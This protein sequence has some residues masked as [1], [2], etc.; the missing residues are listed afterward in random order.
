MADTTLRPYRRSAALRDVSVCSADPYEARVIGTRIYHPHHVSILGN[1][2]DFS[3]TIDAASIG[4]VTVGWLTYGTEVRIETQEFVDSYQINL[5]TEGVMDARC[6][7]EQIVATR[8]LAMVYRPDRPT[9]FSGWRTP[10]PMLAVKVTRHALERELEQLLD[11][12]VAGPIDF[13]LGLDVSSGRGAEW[14]NLLRMIASSLADED[15]LV[16]QPVIAAPLVHSVLTGLLLTARHEYREEL[17]APSPAAGPTA[18]RRARAFIEAHAAEPLTVGRI[19][20][21]AGVSIR[22]LQHGFQRVLGMSPTAYLRAVRLR[23]A[24]RDLVS[25]DRETASVAAVAAQWGFLHPG[26]FA[27][28]YRAMYGVSPGATL[29]RAR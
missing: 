9:A 22:A 15:A 18:V 5:L 7:D 26:R 13:D 28:R 8:D 4:P 17:D 3:M 19:A 23:G 11:R 21:E 29:R 10:T 25:A 16:R 14:T 24:R 12:P 20:A 1:A 27:A 2:Q 6:G